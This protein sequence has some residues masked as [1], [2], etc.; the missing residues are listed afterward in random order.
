M[1]EF[2]GTHAPFFEE[3]NEA[4]IKTCVGGSFD[5]W[6]G[7][8]YNACAV[9]TGP[10]FQDVFYKHNWASNVKLI[11]YYM[12]YGYAIFFLSR[13]VLTYML[14]QWNELGRYSVS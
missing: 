10:D 6:A 5:P 8:G 7:P 11:S 9:L 12:I 14:L 3:L 1:P 4:D 2:Q 13:F